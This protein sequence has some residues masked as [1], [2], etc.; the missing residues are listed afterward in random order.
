MNY[1]YFA[2]GMCKPK[3]VKTI[4]SQKGGRPEKTGHQTE[5]NLRGFAERETK[6]IEMRKS[7]IPSGNCA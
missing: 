7:F 2:D 6:C 4:Y 3:H 1:S 5:Q